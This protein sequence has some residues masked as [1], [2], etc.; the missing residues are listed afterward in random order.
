MVII[1]SLEAVNVM[2]SPRVGIDDIISENESVNDLLVVAFRSILKLVGR[3]SVFT[4]ENNI[5]S[6]FIECFHNFQTLLIN[7]IS[8]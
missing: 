3:K 4:L 6:S 7:R 2:E 1:N 8:G 5:V